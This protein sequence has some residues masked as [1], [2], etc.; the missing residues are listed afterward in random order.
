MF[1]CLDISTNYVSNTHEAI[2]FRLWRLVERLAIILNITL[3]P[4]QKEGE[5]Y[6]LII[7]IH[8]VKDAI[9][10]SS[11]LHVIKKLHTSQSSNE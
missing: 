5:I 8:A 11:L 3:G 4:S 6:G 9:F 2:F 1:I 7:H 10:C